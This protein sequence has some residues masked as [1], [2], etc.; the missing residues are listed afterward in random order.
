MAD[1]H[2]SATGSNTFGSGTVWA[3]SGNQSF[4]LA[5]SVTKRARATLDQ[6]EMQLRTYT[7]TGQTKPSTV[8]T[9]WWRADVWI[10]DNEDTRILAGVYIRQFMPIASGA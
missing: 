5:A 6:A 7:D 9:H 4:E 1:T 2:V 10:D 3:I 8:L